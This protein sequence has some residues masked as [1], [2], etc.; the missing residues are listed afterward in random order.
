MLVGHISTGLFFFPVDCMYLKVVLL[1]F[2]SS[3]VAVHC[4][5]ITVLTSFVDYKGGQER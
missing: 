2:K 4:W 1:S 3:L 5:C